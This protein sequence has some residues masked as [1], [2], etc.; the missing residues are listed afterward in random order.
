MHET[1]HFTPHRFARNIERDC[2][3]NGQSFP[4][5]ATLEIPAGFLHRDPEH[6]PDPDKF[7]PERSDEQL[8]LGV[9]SYYKILDLT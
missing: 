7:I 8:D 4:K 5:G 3:V 1:S 6:W 9:A 2:V